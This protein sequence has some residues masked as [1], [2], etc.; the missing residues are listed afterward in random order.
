M[1]LYEISS[2]RGHTKRVAEPVVRTLNYNIFYLFID[3]DLI[4]GV[5][6]L[7]LRSDL[8]DYPARRLTGLAER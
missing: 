1:N 4:L 2:N 5:M 8:P 7:D 3:H 6:I